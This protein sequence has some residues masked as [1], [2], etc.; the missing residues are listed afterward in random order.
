MADD[1]KSQ[2]DK[3]EEPSERRLREAVEKGDVPHSADINSVFLLG[4]F[5]LVIGTAGPAGVTFMARGKVWF[6]S[7]GR[8]GT[9]ASDVL[10]VSTQF[11]LG[12]GVVLLVPLGIFFCGRI[13][14]RDFST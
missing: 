5:A 3:T 9:D 11:L 10:S 14:R 2:E 13:S 6:E 1:E 7:L 4:G 8:V 12:V